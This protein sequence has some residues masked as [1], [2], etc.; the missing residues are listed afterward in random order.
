VIDV[1]LLSVIRRWRLRDGLAIREI[2]RRTGLSRT[3]IRKYLNNDRVEPKYAVRKSASK[4]DAF[5][6]KLT[7]WLET[8]PR[9]NR[10][11][12]RNLRQMFADLVALDYGGSYD[13]VVAF[14]RQ[15]RR[16]QREAAMI[17]GGGTFVPPVF[18]PGEA[19]QFDWSE[20]WAA[21]GGERMK[22]KLAHSRAFTLRV[23]GGVP[24]RG[25]YDNMKTAVD[26]IGCG[27]AR[28]VNARFNAMTSHY[29]FEATFCNPASGWEKGQVEKNVQDAR[30]RVWHNVPAFASLG[31]LNAWLEQRCLALWH[32][33]Q[34]P[35][36]KART[37]AQVWA[38]EQPHLMVLPPP[39]DGFVEHTKRV[40]PTCLLNFERDRY[41]VPSP[42]AN[43]PVSLR[44]CAKRLVVVAEGEVIAAHVR[45]LGHSHARPSR[46]VYNWRHYLAIVQRK[47]GALRNG[48]PFTELPGAFKRLQSILLKRLSGHREMGRFWRWCCIMTSKPCCAWSNLH[49][50]PM[51]YPSS[52]F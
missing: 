37:I 14:A 40:S 6:E 25:L 16:R 38:D 45:L 11:Q 32:E 21:I 27:K 51:A 4:L 18:A 41:C 10:K 1:A 2:A 33:V 22:F 15:W 20:D 23:L 5:E 46:T 49:S 36:D 12:R 35:E 44:V 3:T 26:R 52:I 34:H 47:P 42:F 50:N 7:K 8:E 9:K 28:R 31:A 48:A 24:T 17:A 13:Q 29:L 19:F 30:P 43:R 39:F